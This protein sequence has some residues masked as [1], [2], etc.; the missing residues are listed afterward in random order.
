MRIAIIDDELH[1]IESLT[2]HLNNLFPKMDIVYKTNNPKDALF[3]IPK[4]KPDLIFLDV[5][6]PAMNGFELLEQ[7][8]DH[9]YDIIFTTAYS[10]YAVKAFK[11]KAVDYLLKPIDEQ[12]LKDAV[13]QWEKTKTTA[14]GISSPKVE[15]LLN[16]LKSEGFLKTKI[17]IPVVDGIE[18][19]NVEDIMYCRSQSNYSTFHFSDGRKTLVSKTIKEIEKTMAPYAFQ[20]VHRS[21]LINPDYMKKY[22]RGDGGYLIMEDDQVI[23][24]SKQHKNI[25]TGLFDSIKK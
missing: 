3:E 13:L 25:V 1:C 8:P 20:R 16:Y 12:E 6:M 18:F 23:P 11:A 24:V 2:I 4:I 19:E 5:E 9:Q 22:N 7:L 17:A 15:E 14:F 10:Q 21:F